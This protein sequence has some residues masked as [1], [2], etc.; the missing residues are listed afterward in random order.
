MSR[1]KIAFTIVL[2]PPL[3]L[4]QGCQDN[5]ILPETVNNSHTPRLLY[6]P[7]IKPCKG[8]IT[9]DYFGRTYHAVEIGSQC[10]LRENL[11]VGIMI[12][13]RDSSKD[14]NVIE[15]FC[16]NDSIE[17]CNKY[18]G[19]YQWNEAMQYT[20]TPRAR[21]ICPSGW[22]VPDYFEYK[23]LSSAV[24]GNGNALKAIGQGTGDGT[25]T[26]ASGFSALLAGR[27]NRYRSFDNFS[28]SAFFGV[29]PSLIGRSRTS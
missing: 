21:G 4:L 8:I 23:T 25:G 17:S 7:K 26:N 24:G 9:V 19:L 29:P 28:N 13:G 14:N 16:Y 11:D 27:R 18:G 2:I 1:N 6:A 12:Q 20:T 22:H 10:W 3:L 15:K 5:I